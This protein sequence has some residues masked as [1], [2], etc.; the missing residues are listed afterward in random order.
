MQNNKEAEKQECK[1]VLG[2]IRACFGSSF[3]K[4]ERDLIAALTSNV[5]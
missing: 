3:S 4:L 2:Y 5:K 1:K